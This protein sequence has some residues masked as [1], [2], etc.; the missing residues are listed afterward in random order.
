MNDKRTTRP[1]ITDV[2]EHFPELGALKKTALRLFPRPDGALRVDQSKLGGSFMWPEHE[3]WPFC[4]KHQV[5]YVSLI[6]IL[7]S[8]IPELGFPIGADL[9]QMIWCPH[10][11]QDS[12]YLPARAI[13]WRSMEEL[14]KPYAD[15]PQ[16]RLNQEFLDTD[17]GDYVPAQCRFYPEPI[18]EYP[19]IEELSEEMQWKLDKWDISAIP[20]IT[21]SPVGAHMETFSPG[22]SL[23]ISE[24]SAASGTKVGG[25]PD[26]IQGPAYPVCS[27]GRHMEHLLSISSLET[28]IGEEGNRWIPIEESSLPYDEG[29][30]LHYGTH[31]M[32]GDGGIVYVFSCRHCDGWPIQI[33]WQSG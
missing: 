13:Y 7:K 11:H 3:D 27:C 4:S 29:Y 9:F 24:L 1:P 16:A 33:T 26:W 30:E 8:E 31:L 2:T 28:V 20:G 15:I 23:Y 25:Y 22:T 10:T 17:A 18:V 5:P 19:T 32:F 12:D 21:E 6:Q 14:T